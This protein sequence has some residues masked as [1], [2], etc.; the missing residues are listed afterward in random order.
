MQTRTLISEFIQSKNE[1]DDFIG[2]V[3]EVQVE[4]EA[5]LGLTASKTLVSSVM[6]EDLGMKYCKILQ[7]AVHTNSVRNLILR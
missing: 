2:T 4:L 1:N 6:R 5:K 7:G 3:K